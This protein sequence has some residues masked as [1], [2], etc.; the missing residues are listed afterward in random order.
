MS[1]LH[2]ALAAL[3]VT[4]TAACGGPSALTTSDGGF[5]L[6]AADSLARTPE[7]DLD[8]AAAGYRALLAAADW[9]L[10]PD[11]SAHV[12]RHLARLAPLAPRL[13]LDG[14]L[15]TWPTGTGADALRWW[16]AHD[17]APAT[18]PNER[19]REH[20]ERGRLADAEYVSTRHP[21]GLDGRGRLLLRLGEPEWVRS[22]Y[23]LT[24]A[25]ASGA[26]DG[27]FV[28]PEIWGYPSV[29]DAAV[30]LFTRGEG[31][32]EEVS[33]RELLPTG[34]QMGPSLSRSGETTMIARG[35]YD[36]LR[37]VAFTTPEYAQIWDRAAR[38]LDE[39]ALASDGSRPAGLPPDP[40]LVDLLEVDRID[41]ELRRRRAAEVPLTLTRA[42]GNAMGLAVDARPLRFRQP[43]GSTR[44]E[45][46]WTVPPDALTVSPIEWATLSSLTDADRVTGLDVTLTTFDADYEAVGFGRE[47][48]VLDDE[49]AGSG[50]A[51]RVL[52]VQ[53]FPP[54]G[55][56]ALGVEARF[57]DVVA[58]RAVV[59]ADT[60]APLRIA[61]FEV[62]DIL[63]VTLPAEQLAADPNELALADYLPF[64]VTGSTLRRGDPLA[65][66][67]EV[68]G[69][70][71]GDDGLA[72]YAVAY[73]VTTE[74]PRGGLIGLFGGRRERRAASAL[75]NET[76][77]GRVREAVAV[78]LSA[79]LPGDDHVTLELRVTDEATGASVTRSLPLRIVE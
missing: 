73:D 79:L 36:L 47:R 45:L 68:Y 10:A 29:S 44:V 75:T 52:Q 15:R 31:G 37:P 21:S 18:V 16:R 48:L 30:Y 69:L 39:V 70:S 77:A 54:D 62:S 46:V 25:L 3:L 20:L 71:P 2:V 43:D 42:A 22:P 5:P 55:S 1:R 53:P 57:G 41:R 34:L 67:F 28:R 35:L 65:V 17:P 12:R 49:A 6:A 14:D 27:L 76:E 60:L 19:L 61:G 50:L 64:A 9:A 13:G 24:L 78:D 74:G 11:D 40:Y 4:G 59:R 7:A 23:S 72:R 51:P 32:M 58:R 56:L 26:A 33:A 38:Y 8:R 66:V 63:P